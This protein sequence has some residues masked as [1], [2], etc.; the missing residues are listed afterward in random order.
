MFLSFRVSLTPV[1]ILCCAVLEN[2]NAILSHV[3]GFK[4]KIYRWL[5]FFCYYE[6]R[7]FWGQSKKEFKITFALSRCNWDVC[8]AILLLNRLHSVF[9]VTK[10][11]SMHCWDAFRL[12]MLGSAEFG[13][14]LFIGDSEEKE[15]MFL[16]FLC[17]RFCK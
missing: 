17:Y 11:S 9:L 14:D 3:A 12:R 13:L 6:I 16:F 5:C 8:Y 1:T 2:A 4:H 10:S 7:M 15:K